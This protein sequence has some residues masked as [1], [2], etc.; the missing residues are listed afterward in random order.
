LQL[1]ASQLLLSKGSVDDLQHKFETQAAVTELLRMLRPGRGEDMATGVAALPPVQVPQG[2]GQQLTPAATQVQVPSNAAQQQQQ[3]QQQAAA[4]AQQQQ[5]P[6]QQQARAVALAGNSATGPSDAAM[7]S[8]AAAGALAA[9]AL[10]P[11]AQQELTACLSA[12]QEWDEVRD[13]IGV[14]SGGAGASGAGGAGGRRPVG[15]AKNKAK[16]NDAARGA[17]K[18]RSRYERYM[19]V[20]TF[21][22]MTPPEQRR[23][24]LKVPMAALLKGALRGLATARPRMSAETPWLPCRFRWQR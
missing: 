15:K 14:G 24:L 6:Q 10:P 18:E 3:Q 8:R 7:S 20:E 9:H 22:R 21:W 1:W 19:D 4:P 13:G 5:Q 12:E 11:P 17:R 23:A 2:K 16:G